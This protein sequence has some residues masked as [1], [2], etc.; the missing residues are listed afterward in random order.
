MDVPATVAKCLATTFANASICALLSSNVLR[1]FATSSA[2]SQSLY[3][4]NAA[5]LFC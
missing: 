1:T 5:A 2:S 4:V 3:G